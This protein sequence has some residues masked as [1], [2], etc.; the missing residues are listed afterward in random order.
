MKAAEILEKRKYEM[1]TSDSRIAAMKEYAGKF[2][3]WCS[4]NEWSFK[5][6]DPE[7][8]YGNGSIWLQ[9]LPLATS[10]YTNDTAK[11]TEELLTEFENS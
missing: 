4:N 3:E 1:D 8:G 2:A 6:A 10:F 9:A 5:E 7:G 11:T